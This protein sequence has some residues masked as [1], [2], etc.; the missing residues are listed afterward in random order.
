[1]NYLF[2]IEKHKCSYK[3]YKYLHKLLNVQIYMKLKH[4]QVIKEMSLT[5]W[6][7][8]KPWIGHVKR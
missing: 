5:H 3:Y 2:M 8:E 1:M 6:Y 7:K 4:E